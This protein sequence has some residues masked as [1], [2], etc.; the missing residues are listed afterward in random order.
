MLKPV[1]VFI[2]SSSHSG[3]TWLGYV[4]GS[5]QQAAFVGELSRAWDERRRVPCTVC[6][7]RGN[8]ICPI[9]GGIH[10]VTP[11]SAFPLL[12]ART[13]KTV[14][15]DN[16]KDIEWTK[17]FVNHPDRDLRIVHLVKD[18]RSRWASLRRRG[19]TNLKDCIAN[20][21]VENQQIMK[22]TRSLNVKTYVAA[23]DIV[24]ADQETEI[25]AIFD[26]LSM[27]FEVSA[28]RYWDVDHHALAANGATSALVL[29]QKFSAPPSH[30]ST[31]DDSFYQNAF[32]RTFVDERWRSELPASE[33]ESILNNLLVGELLHGLGYC[34]TQGGI[35]RVESHP[36][37]LLA[38]RPIDDT[39]QRILSYFD[40]DAYLECYPDVVAGIEAGWFVSGRAHFEAHGLKEGRIPGAGS[41]SKKL[42]GSIDIASSL[43]IEIGAL[44]NPI[45]TKAEG[46]ILYVDYTDRDGLIE[47]YASHMSV[48]PEKIVDVDAVWGQQ[49]LIECLPTGTVADYV[50]ASH[51]VEHVPDI[52]GWLNEISDVLCDGG[53]IKLAVP[54]KRY[55]FDILRRESQI[56]DLL[57]AFIRKARKPLPIALLDYLIWQR[58][59]D[60]V[61]AWLG[62]L[63]HDSLTPNYSLREAIEITERVAKA[64]AYF[65]THCWVFTPR[66][67]ALAMEQAT[68]ANIIS[69]ECFEFHDTKPLQLEF[70]VGMSRTKDR[71]RA[72]ESWRKVG[73]SVGGG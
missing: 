66:S 14:I 4:L 29:H 55:T 28:L 5:G 39:Q 47:H 37:K 25:A 7:S 16:S 60:C 34:L 69:L 57:D 56:Q 50:I 62:K 63:D 13:G 46:R 27:P 54:D 51:V 22:F 9:L 64:D 67:F 43:G 17:Q 18:P 23:Y 61:D 48:D 53:Q 26:F 3:S 68:A 6:A 36:Q 42:R 59:V 73:R 65:D 24:A 41:R 71:E 32:G 58:T 2:H 11:V 31:G 33:N 72:I 52:L 45:V 30:F 19:S 38:Q 21:C 15:I 20:W 44:T 12:S 40:E 8:E 10:N 49:R 35:E 1:D 70:F